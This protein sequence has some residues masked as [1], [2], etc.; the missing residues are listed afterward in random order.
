MDADS[1]AEEIIKAILGGDCAVEI[2]I[3]KMMAAILP[4]LER[5]EGEENLE[6][7]ARRSRDD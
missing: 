2:D 7:L 3:A 1:V 6:Q 5:I 4:I